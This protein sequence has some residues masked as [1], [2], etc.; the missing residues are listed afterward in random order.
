MNITESTQKIRQY[1]LSEYLDEGD[2]ATF[3]TKT[4][5]IT[6][7]LIDSISILQVVDFLEENFGFEFEPHE[8]DQSNLNTVELILQFIQEK[9]GVLIQK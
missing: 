1:L 9:K 4:P 8:V 2:A 7:G 5:L 6:S 3:T